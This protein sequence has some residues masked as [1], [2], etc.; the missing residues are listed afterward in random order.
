A[1]RTRPL[2]EVHDTVRNRLVASR[3]AELAKTDGSE[4]LV[5]WKA[6]APAN[7]PAAVTVTREQAQNM[8]GPILDAVLR[9]DPEHLPAW[10]GVDLG[11]KGYA[12]VRVNK[13]LP[14]IAPSPERAEQ[15][16]NQF[17]QWIAKAENQ[18]YYNVLK[19]RYKAVIKVPRP[20]RN[21]QEKQAA[22]Q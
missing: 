20:E 9:A 15:E 1:A 21:T 8:Q 3:S 18:A 14:R 16:R 2:S 22:A 19:D 7:L 17:T 4:K 13:V 11:S 10:V 5:A 6:T 12:I